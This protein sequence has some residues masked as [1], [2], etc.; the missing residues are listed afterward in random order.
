MR[1]MI[2]SLLVASTAHAEVDSKG[3]HVGAAI[4]G[5][6]QIDQDGDPNSQTA[7]SNPGWLA[8]AF[9]TWR[10]S[11]T[12]A[13]QLEIDVSNKRLFT[14]QCQPC[15]NTGSISLWYAEVPALLRLDLLPGRTKF[16]FGAGTEIAIPLGGTRSFD[17]GAED[18][19]LDE[20]M[21]NFGA[22]VGVGLEI[23]AGIGAITVDLRYK[24]WL[25]GV[26]GT[27]DSTEP[28]QGLGGTNPYVSSSHQVV[29]AAGYAF[30]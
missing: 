14:E 27:L 21:P 13:I 18:L 5:V 6:G 12:F 2:A 17:D 20:L 26:T 29:L 8:G 1:V 10:R 16:Y 15:M 24:R 7:N 28:T 9:V 11:P 4:F 25:L 19:R 22:I 3:V 30:P 23:P